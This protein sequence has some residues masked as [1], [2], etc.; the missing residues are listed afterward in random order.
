MV[1]GMSY[2]GVVPQYR[3]EKGGKGYLPLEDA[4][5]R[6]EASAALLWL[7]AIFFP[8]SEPVNAYKAPGFLSDS[9]SAMPVRCSISLP[10]P[11]RCDPFGKG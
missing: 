9:I 5:V 6:Q 4:V 8:E 7:E 10:F 11:Q 3:F 2:A 1:S